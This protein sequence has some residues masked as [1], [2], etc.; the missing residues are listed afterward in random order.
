MKKTVMTVF[1]L[2]IFSTF[3]IAFAQ[4]TEKIEIHA[5]WQEKKN[6]ILK[7]I[8]VNSV[9]LSE[10]KISSIKKV[11]ESKEY[12]IE[13]ERIF[14]EGWTGALQFIDSKNTRFDIIVSEKMI[15]GDI[16]LE[17]STRKNPNYNGWTT[18]HYEDD[19]IAMAN[20]EIFDANNIPTI[21]LENLVRHE[22][23]HALGL[24]HASS[25]DDLMHNEIGTKHKFISDCALEGLKFLNNGFRFTSVDCS[26]V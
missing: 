8:I 23:G 17:L 4:S 22:V 24:A 15:S 12:H 20:I 25:N 16:V 5:S 7:F 9:N 14:F 3:S 26:F 6:N 18:P 21:Q 10:E 11:I 13:D 2:L 1:T 19:Y